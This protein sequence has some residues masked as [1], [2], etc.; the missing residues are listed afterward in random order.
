MSQDD[1]YFITYEE[2]GT[3]IK[4]GGLAAVG[5][6]AISALTNYRISQEM[7]HEPMASDVFKVAAVFAVIAGVVWAILPNAAN[8]P[9]DHLE[10]V[11][12]AVS[13]PL[14]VLIV[15]MMENQ[16]EL[17]RT[18]EEITSKYSTS[19]GSSGWSYVRNTGSGRTD[20]YMRGWNKAR[21]SSI[22][23]TDEVDVDVL[24]PDEDD[25][26]EEELQEFY[27]DLEDKYVV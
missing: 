10:D 22:F 18:A 24:P 25:I 20:S 17:S 3:R 14:N 12:D 7:L 13:E 21:P 2:V 19:T 4:N 6:F 15:R 16:R 1:K 23:D 5:A 26:T 27:R 11:K 8:N 9:D